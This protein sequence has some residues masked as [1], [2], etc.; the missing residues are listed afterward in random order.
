MSQPKII[1]CQDYINTRQRPNIGSADDD[2][3]NVIV[4]PIQVLT[5]RKILSSFKNIMNDGGIG[6]EDTRR[7]V[8][9]HNTHRRQP[10]RATLTTHAAKMFMSDHL[11][12]LKSHSDVP[13]DHLS[14]HGSV[15]KANRQRRQIRHK[16]YHE[17]RKSEWVA[18]ESH[19]GQLS[20]AVL[21]ES[22]TRKVLFK[23]PS[24]SGPV[25][26]SGSAVPRGSWI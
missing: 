4:L 21:V 18:D 7:F 12:K 9:K 19:W 16:V 14:A 17:H 8:C 22:G 1:S 10:P 23:D 11:H 20:G 5:L 6:L 25:F 24:P 13:R 26:G 2:G 3:K 15:Y